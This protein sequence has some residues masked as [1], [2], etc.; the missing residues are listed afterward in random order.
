MDAPELLSSPPGEGGPS[1]AGILWRRKGYVIFFL[2][3]GLGGGYAYFTQATEIYQA[4]AVI[5]VYR[6]Q[7]SDDEASAAERIAAMAPNV[8][9]I[10]AEV[11]SDPVLLS[12]VELGN[13][14]EL[15]GMPSNPSEAVGAIRQ[16]LVLE[17]AIEGASEQDRSIV[18]VSFESGDP[19]LCA[20]VVN[21]VVS[22]YEEYVGG[23]HQRAVENV[24]GVF[25]ESRD[26]IL[27]QLN[28]LEEEYTAFRSKA[29]LEW[30]SD[31]E[32][33]NPFRED[34]L[35][36]ET[37]LDA[38]Q[39]EARQLTNKLK[40]IEESTKSHDSAVLVLQEIQYLLDEVSDVKA[41]ET[42]LVEGTDAEIEIQNRLVPLLIQADMLGTQYG[43]NHPARKN[44]ER[45]IEATR[46]ALAELERTKQALAED[47]SKIEARREEGARTLLRSYVNGLQ[48]KKQLIED[49]IADAEERLAEARERAHALIA[50]ENENASYT[51]RIARY[52]EMLDSFDSQLERS[53]L[54]LVNPGLEVNTLRPAGMGYLVGPLLSKCLLLGAFLG[55]AVGAG[56]GWLVDWSERT[57]RSPD[58]VSQALDLPILAHLPL[59]TRPRKRRRRKQAS[60][61]YDSIDR[62]IVVLH[63]PQSPTA[64]AVRSVRTSLFCSSSKDLEFQVIQVT[65]ALSGDG[66][67]TFVANLAA[68]LAN[69]NKRV[70]VIDADLRRPTQNRLFGSDS[71][72]GLTTVLNGD[73]SLA[74][75]VVPTAVEGLYLLPCGAKPSNP[76][77]ALTLRE[78]GQTIDDLRAEFDMI[79]ID[80]P[81]LLAVTDAANVSAN[82]DGVLFVMRIGRN[83]KP[84][85]R[86]ATQMLR[87][88]HVNMIG[89]VVNAIGDSGY[90][91]TYASNWSTEYGGR[92]GTEYGYGYDSKVSGAYL[93]A[94]K[95]GTVTVRGKS[96]VNEAASRRSVEGHR[97]AESES[98]PDDEFASITNGHLR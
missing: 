78:F 57:F 96:L 80:T 5:E 35:R 70:V 93:G 56:L 17:S 46:K 36:M 26:S 83:I 20:A 62:S 68:S 38:M 21:A 65:S 74:E 55:A 16:G 54:P 92:P 82:V 44:V 87:S 85:A 51:R 86:R 9:Y 19:R 8:G 2:L 76:S 43:E 45:Q 48:K 69:A 37:Q 42:A 73:C 7:S 81:P 79:L 33:V 67:S 39:T 41:L 32:A 98:T 22:A 1:L 50:F 6:H 49:D 12:A 4:A 75:A 72:I 15:P 64:E 89:I 34:V 66:K 59:I 88:L 84:L 71:E 3:V 77:E 94:S 63:D 11:T 91:A 29:P 23:R 28:K 25:R 97:Q 47:E 31:G 60:G 52:Q 95:G 53:S 58:E 90:S 27:P 13:L 10:R 61:A 30:T 14:T 40:L 18:E 24:V